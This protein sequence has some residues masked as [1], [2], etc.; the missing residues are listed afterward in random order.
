M[1]PLKSIK[2]DC[3]FEERYSEKQK[4]NYKALFIRIS[5]DYEKVV[6]LSV[7]EQKLLE[8]NS[9]IEKVDFSNFE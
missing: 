7:P 2:V 6:F 9:N 5:D 1:L 4:K 8:S 3:T